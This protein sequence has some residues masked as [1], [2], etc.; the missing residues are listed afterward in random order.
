[1][2]VH[3]LDAPP[4]YTGP[5]RLEQ[6]EGERIKGFNEQNKIR[7]ADGG[8]V[9]VEV[10]VVDGSPGHPESVGSKDFGIKKEGQAVSNLSQG[11]VVA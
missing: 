10:K 3:P 5:V 9:K 4:G 1:M 2:A 7:S 6:E 11:F 8:G